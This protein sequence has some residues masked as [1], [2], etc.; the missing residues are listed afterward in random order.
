[1]K[2]PLYISGLIALALSLAPARAEVPAGW[3]TNLLES[4]KSATASNRPVILYFTASWC[5]PCRQMARSTLSDSSVLTTLGEYVPVALDLDLHPQDA[6]D[7]HVSA[8]PAFLVLTPD[9]QEVTRSTGYLDADRFQNFLTA[10]LLA[11]DVARDRQTEFSRMQGEVR[12]ALKEGDVE[13]RRRA[14]GQLFKL[15]TDRES[16]RQ[17]FALEQI[18]AVA[19]TTPAD[20]VDG[21]D[22][23]QLAVRLSV[24][25]AL[26]EKFGEHFE[27]DPWAGPE[28]RRAVAAI[29][30][31]SLAP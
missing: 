2:V 21:L 9:G 28:E 3:R 4:L 18:R 24:G 8:I 14:L 7:R 30:R 12:A 22:H 19:R 1:M 31:K 17:E 15:C 20:L 26:R 23:T 27:Y 11:A 16:A 25:N 5:G 29:W 10:G 6:T 13:G